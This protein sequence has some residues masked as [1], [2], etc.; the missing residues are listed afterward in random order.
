MVGPPPP[1]A[2]RHLG[3]FS[4]LPDFQSLP[5]L[6]DPCLMSFKQKQGMFRDKWLLF[7]ATG[8]TRKDA[9]KVRWCIDGAQQ[10]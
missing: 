6:N 4:R 9:S 5:A 10:S 3:L 8:N 2:L 1:A 7:I